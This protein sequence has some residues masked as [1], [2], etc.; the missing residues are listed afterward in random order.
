MNDMYNLKIY[1]ILIFNI[2]LT[3]YMYIFK[4]NNI[5]DYSEIKKI[6]CNKREFNWYDCEADI[7][8][9]GKERNIEFS[10]HKYWSNIFF[11]TP[12]IG[13]NIYISYDKNNINNINY[14]TKFTY[15][16]DKYKLTSLLISLSLL[17]SLYYKILII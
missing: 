12:K 1:M 10:I 13:D 4:R 5:Y 17:L 6:K 15:Y 14:E 2:F 8:Y 11:S 16:T 9:N 3:L 7:D